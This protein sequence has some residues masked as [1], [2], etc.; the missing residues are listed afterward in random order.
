[1]KKQ[2]TFWI[3]IAILAIIGTSSFASTNNYSPISAST[4]STNH[5]EA[6]VQA[7][8]TSHKQEL[9]HI[10]N[11]I[12][13]SNW[14]ISAFDQ[15]VLPN[16]LLDT[17]W[18][19]QDSESNWLTTM[20]ETDLISE[21]GQRIEKYELPLLAQ[22]YISSYNSE[23]LWVYGSDGIYTVLLENGVI[24]QYGLH[25]VF[26]TINTLFEWE[27][28]FIKDEASLFGE[29]LDT[30][31]GEDDWFDYVELFWS[32]ISSVDLPPLAR[33]DVSTYATTIGSIHY[34]SWIY[35]VVLEDGT[36]LQYGKNWVFYTV[37]SL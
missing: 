17:W 16:A 25:W 8:E 26:L 24:L 31:A 3:T 13:R 14:M 23:I 9:V 11:R 35:T 4:T 5:I 27:I 21:Y 30:W 19:S 22:N 10:F 29:L 33:Y 34:L 32:S 20:Y 37:E 6:Q 7:I 12:K 15:E 36:I 2:T 18:P 28:E 1:M